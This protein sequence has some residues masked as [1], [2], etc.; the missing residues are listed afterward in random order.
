MSGDARVNTLDWLGAADR[1][2]PWGEATVLV[3]GLGT[4]GFAAAD[5][6]AALHSGRGAHEE[7]VFRPRP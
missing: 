3:A 5:A 1:L 6:L 4:S 2:S 7:P